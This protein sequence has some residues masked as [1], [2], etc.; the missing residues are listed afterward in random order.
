[1]ITQQKEY[2]AIFDKEIRKYDSPLAKIPPLKV[3][4]VTI[5]SIINLV[6]SLILIS[7]QIS[8]KFSWMST[9]SRKITFLAAEIVGL[10]HVFLADLLHSRHISASFLVRGS[11]TGLALLSSF[12]S[13]LRWAA[14]LAGNLN[15]PIRKDC[16]TASDFKSRHNLADPDGGSLATIAPTSGGIVDNIIEFME[17]A[18][19][20]R[21]IAR[22]DWFSKKYWGRTKH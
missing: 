5:S 17:F 7:R 13:K 20:R 16:V 21:K 9:I 3:N 19:H 15:W 10:V 8:S 22:Y 11:W 1:M 14:E 4:T 2:S 18:N 6:K 12:S